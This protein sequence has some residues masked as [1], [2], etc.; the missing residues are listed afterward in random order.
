MLVKEIDTVERVKETV[1]IYQTNSPDIAGPD[2]V[3]SLDLDD[4][5]GKMKTEYASL[6]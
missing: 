4:N 3:S 5:D 2:Q 1:M 6:M